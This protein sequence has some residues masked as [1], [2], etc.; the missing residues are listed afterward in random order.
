MKTITAYF[1]VQNEES[2]IEYSITNPLLIMDKVVVVDGGSVDHTKKIIQAVAKKL[3]VNHKLFLYDKP[4]TTLN[5]QRNFALSKCDTDFIMYLDADEVMDVWELQKIK[6][7]YIRQYDLIL[8]HSNHLYI[9]WWHEAIHS[10]SW[11]SSW[12][13]PRVFRRISGMYYTDFRFNE[14]DH[15]LYIHNIYFK[16]YF[17][18][19]TKFCDYNDI[20]IKHYGHAMGRD[21]EHKKIMFHMW[22]DNSESRKL[23][24]EE[25]SK[26]AWQSC[27][28]DQRFWSDGM[29]ADPIGVIPFTGKHPEI[30]KSHPLY[31]NYVIKK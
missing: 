19:K 31:N 14:G 30:M 15:T 22:Y 17:K 8:I 6:N 21:A 16:D 23:S 7:E 9:D 29:N 1:I 20:T 25:L 26:R 4:F 28:F 3:N 12:D 18:N 2:I 11:F 10:G 5:D 24:K 13:M 27:Y